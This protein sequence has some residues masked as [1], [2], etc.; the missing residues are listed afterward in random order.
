MNVRECRD[1]THGVQNINV[2]E[3]CP[4]YHKQKDRCLIH[5]LLQMILIEATEQEPGSFL[6]IVQMMS[7]C[8]MDPNSSRCSWYI[9][10]LLV[11]FTFHTCS[12]FF[13]NIR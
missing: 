7:T 9:L 2:Y 6:E 11:L 3:S 13:Q 5:S 12:I 10:V 8:M 1:P 4:K